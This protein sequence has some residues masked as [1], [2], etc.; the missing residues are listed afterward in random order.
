MI[1]RIQSLQEQ[2]FLHRDI[3]PDNFLIGIDKNSDKVYVIDFGLTKRYLDKKKKHIPLK[4]GKKLT[5]TARY[6]SC[7]THLGLE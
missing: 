6:A 7:N 1:L 2:F 3:K 5:G 4:K